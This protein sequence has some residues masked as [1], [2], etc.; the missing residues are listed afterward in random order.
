MQL[1]NEAITSF[2]K[3][4]REKC[5]VWLDEEEAKTKAL[6]ELKRFSLIYK[7]ILVSDEEVLNKLRNKRASN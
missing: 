3:L 2:Q 6:K 4:Y 7:P 5:G 1:S